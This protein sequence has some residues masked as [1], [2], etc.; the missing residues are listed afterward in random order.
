MVDTSELIAGFDWLD[1]DERGFCERVWATDPAVYAARLRAIGFEGLGR[2]LDAGCGFGQWTLPLAAVNDAVAAIDYSPARTRALDAILAARG[3]T[4]VTV[5]TG[6]ISA[7]PY[8]D[9]SFDGIFSYSV[10]YFTDFE[11]SLA[12][13]ARVARPGA[14]V[15]ICTNGLGWYLHNIRAAPYASPTFDPAAMGRETIDH[16]LAYY[17]GLGYRPGSQ[18]VMPQAVTAAALDRHGFD[19]IGM[20]GE[21]ECAA[22]G[23]TPGRSFFQAEYEGHEGVYEVIAER[24]A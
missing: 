18:L 19:L 7:L 9:A 21:G 6:S 1:A 11:A 13:F 16:S 24:R 5:A 22:P 17:A 23:R 20:A 3:A 2:V 10:I 12:E 14:R 4:D 8:A 15:Y